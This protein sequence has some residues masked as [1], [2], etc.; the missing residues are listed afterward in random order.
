[1]Y[2]VHKYM[3]Y[4]LLM[5]I[6]NMFPYCVHKAVIVGGYDHVQIMSY[7]VQLAAFIK[8]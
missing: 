6:V 4:V 2:C 8:L 5:Y 1:M 3:Q 7:N